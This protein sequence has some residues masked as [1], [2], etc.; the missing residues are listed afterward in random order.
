MDRSSTAS[1]Q[2]DLLA[3]KVSELDEQ[4]GAM[5][6]YAEAA[7]VSA[8]VVTTVYAALLPQQR[9]ARARQAAAAAPGSDRARSPLWLAALGVTALFVVAAAVRARR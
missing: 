2:R 6:A 1:M 4:L 8:P 9:A 5:V 7:S 3:G